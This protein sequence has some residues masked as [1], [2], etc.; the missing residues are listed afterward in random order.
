MSLHA[1]AP[2]LED[3]DLITSRLMIACSLRSVP[4]LSCVRKWLTVSR[5]IE[6]SSRETAEGSDRPPE[7]SLPSSS[8]PSSS[9]SSSSSVVPTA[10]IAAPAMHINTTHNP[11]IP[12]NTN[13]TTVDTIDEDL[14]HTCPQCDRTFISHI[15]LV[16][17]LRIHR[18]EIGESV[19][20]VPTHTR[21]TRLHCPH[22]SCAYIYR[23]DLFGHM[24]IHENLRAVCG[25]TVKGTTP[26]RGAN[27]A[28]LLTEKAQILKLWAD[29]LRSLLNR[30]FPAIS[31]VV[32]VQLPHVETNVDLDLQPSLH[33]TIRDV[34]QL[35]GIEPSE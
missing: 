2:S 19:P 28:A 22:C 26:L 6:T 29:H 16:G 24:R 32:I 27:Q 30:P 14:D 7:P 11:D 18:T 8:S 10:A 17:R 4:K 35:S 34:Q 3:F 13:T 25:L 5:T 21:R 1:T 33:E 23:M 9:S 12:R 15:G 31:D 20:G